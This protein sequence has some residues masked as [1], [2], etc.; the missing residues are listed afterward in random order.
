MPVPS[1]HPRSLLALMLMA[2]GT[3][4]SRDRLI[5]ELWGERPPASAVSALHV[6]LSKL[7][8]LLGDLLVREPAGTRCAPG[9]SSWTAGGSTSSCRR[10]ARTRAGRGSC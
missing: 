9:S 10:P 8:D 4:L 6:H 5:D 3:P 7:R 1:G 2:G